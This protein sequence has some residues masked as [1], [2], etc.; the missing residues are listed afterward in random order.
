MPYVSVYVD[1]NDVL[2]ELSADDL[3]EALAK[4]TGASGKRELQLL[5]AIYLQQRDAGNATPEMR[6][7]LARTLGRI[8]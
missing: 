8:L 5:E 4:K 6:E 2:E 7:Y 3:R 1:A